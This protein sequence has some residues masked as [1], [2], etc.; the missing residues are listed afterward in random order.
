M[1][2]PP[3]DITCRRSVALA[4]LTT[5][6]SGKQIPERI[7]W[8]LVEA[9]SGVPDVAPHF[10]T[11]D[12]EDLRNFADA[13]RVRRLVGRF[14]PQVTE[15][16]VRLAT[17]SLSIERRMIETVETLR[18]ASVDVLVL[19]GNATAYLDHA[20]PT[21]REVSDIDLLVRPDQLPEA[22]ARLASA[23]AR[24]VVGHPFSVPWSF[25]SETFVQPDGTQID[26]HHRLLQPSRPP[27]TCWR[28][29]DTFQAAGRRMAAL[30]RSW[31]FAHAVVHQLKDSPPTQ[32]SLTG[33]LD[34]VLMWRSGLDLLEVR[35]AA[36]E[37]GTP[38]LV[39]RGIRRL[40][41]LLGE[42]AVLPP[43][44]DVRHRG[45]A[46]RRLAAALDTDRPTPGY[47]SLAAN[48]AVQP[49]RRWPRYMADL[50]WP[51][52]DYRH[53]RGITLSSHARHVLREAIGR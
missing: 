25:H 28:K 6:I 52:A 13:H 24:R 1:A 47:L 11:A 31:R 14:A 22:M 8:A 20:D 53:G 16:P 18:D 5:G 7:T 19:K 4:V 29:P 36:R 37:I 46:E 23:G 30:P 15:D 2:P 21:D 32:R 26:L 38:E 43:H 42:R 48:L 35:A 10:S 33:V 45:W 27:V 51:T 41:D 3:D 34:M 44:G 17:Q 12:H 49:A 9:A 50:L 40:T 39:E